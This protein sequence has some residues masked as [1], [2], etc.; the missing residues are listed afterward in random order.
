MSQALGLTEVTENQGNDQQGLKEAEVYLLIQATS[1]IYIYWIL[2]D[3]E[4]EITF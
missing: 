4:V 1:M 2:L 3:L